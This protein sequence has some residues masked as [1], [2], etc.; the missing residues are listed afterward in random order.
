M[1]KK[2]AIVPLM[3][4]ALLMAGCSGA[5]SSAPSA[6]IV[7]P[8]TAEATNTATSSATATGAKSARGNLIKSVGQGAGYTDENGKQVVTFTINKIAMDPVCTEQYAQAP[9]NGH[10]LALDVSVVTNPELATATGSGTFTM[11]PSEWK[12]IAPNGTTF[13]GFLSGSTFGCLPQTEQ[14]PQSIGPAENVTGTLLLDV[15]STEG[16]LVF[17]P[18]YLGAG[19]EWKFPQ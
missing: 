1:N 4:V 12:L 14:I 17:K 16:T 10:F 2:L 11:S 3:S 6:P 13:N 8:V 9:Q 18:V 19:W 5:V 15:P 7:A